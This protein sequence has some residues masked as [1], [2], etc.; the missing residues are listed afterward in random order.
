KV[1]K[2]IIA[3]KSDPLVQIQLKWDARDADLGLN[4]ASIEEMI[5]QARAELSVSQSLLAALKTAGFPKCAA[6]MNGSHAVAFIYEMPL[7]AERTKVMEQIPVLLAAWKEHAEYDL[8]VCMMEP[9][10]YQQDFQEI[11]SVAYWT[12]ADIRH[13]KYTIMSMTVP[14]GAK[15]NAKYSDK[16]WQFN[17][18]SD[19]TLRWSEQA[20]SAAEAW[21][22]DHLKKTVTLLSI[23]EHEAL[24]NRHGVLLRFPFSYQKNVDDSTESDGVI[25]GEYD[26]DGKQ[27]EDMR[28]EEAAEK[29]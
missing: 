3:E 9:D 20:R 11:A 7:K 1:K 5:R 4:P 15:P 29:K 18:N 2:S 10:K 16:D 21:A 13:T 12:S 23:S 25:V 17:T 14:S 8:D 6:G 24:E 28:L 26:L 27:G 22:K 19:L